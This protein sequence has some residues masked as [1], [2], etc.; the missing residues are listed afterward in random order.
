M[1]LRGINTQMIDF[2]ED[3][4]FVQYLFEFVIEMELD[5]AR[6]Q[7]EAGVDLMG[8]GDAAASLI[9]PKLYEEFVWPYEKRLVDGV[10]KLGEQSG[11]T[12][13][14]IRELFWKVWGVWAVKSLI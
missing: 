11:C 8:I 1:G 2:Y 12:S 7:I 10:H 14:A 6:C 4:G 9:G 5:F 13:A 3:P